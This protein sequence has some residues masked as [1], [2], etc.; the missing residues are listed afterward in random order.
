MSSPFPTLD[1]SQAG[2]SDWLVRLAREAYIRGTIAA[3][4]PCKPLSQGRKSRK[5]ARRV[6]GRRWFFAPLFR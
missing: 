1:G 6:V 4:R 5:D 2:G 3:I